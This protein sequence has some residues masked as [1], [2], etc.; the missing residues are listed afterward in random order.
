[1]NSSAT[2]V[3]E[4]SPLRLLTE[5]HELLL[6]ANKVY[7]DRGN[8]DAAEIFHI[9]GKLTSIISRN[10]EIESSNSNNNHRHE[11]HSPSPYKVLSD[12]TIDLTK[13]NSIKEEEKELLPNCSARVSIHKK[14]PNR[15]ENSEVLIEE[16]SP[17]SVAISYSPVN[18]KRRNNED[19]NIFA[20]TVA[21]SQVCFMIAE[22]HLCIYR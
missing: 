16:R 6:K 10:R 18:R 20:T 7:F 21:E 1:M 11:I 12:S 5:A 14:K 19:R 17:R 22:F 8:Q 4:D 3:N 15:S 9:I 13:D 2:P